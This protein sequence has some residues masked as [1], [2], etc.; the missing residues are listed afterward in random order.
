MSFTLGIFRFTIIRFFSIYGSP[1]TLINNF[2]FLDVKAVILH[3]EF[4]GFPATHLFVV[5]DKKPE[6]VYEVE[7]NGKVCAFEFDKISGIVAYCGPGCFFKAP[8]W[9]IS[10]TSSVEGKVLL[11]DF[12][13]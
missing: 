4:I 2:I 1:I 6:V 13:S 8:F 10:V 7:F 9:D 11:E 12:S 5:L 3:G